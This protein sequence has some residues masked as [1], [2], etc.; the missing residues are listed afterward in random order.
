MAAAG[1]AAASRTM[2]T[3]RVKPPSETCH[4]TCPIAS[5]AG[6][7]AVG[8][9]RAGS[10]EG[11]TDAGA[12]PAASEGVVLVPIETRLRPM[13]SACERPRAERSEAWPPRAEDAPPPRL[14]GSGVSCGV[15]RLE[16]FDFL[17]LA[18]ASASA[19]AAA[20]AASACA[21]A[22]AAALASASAAAAAASRRSWASRRP[23]MPRQRASKRDAARKT[24]MCLR[25]SSWGSTPT[26]RQSRLRP[27][28]QSEGSMPIALIISTHAC[29][30]ACAASSMGSTPSASGGGGAV[31]RDRA[32]A[33]ESTLVHA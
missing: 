14:E 26:L 12:P 24:A 8:S 28:T 18:S 17:P 7:L 33:R 6:S 30:S 9:A 31:G 21:N 27:T 2:R 22:S 10:G 1:A 25:C 15:P 13:P 3:F 16:P 19:A 11:G 32:R 29:R 23:S 5:S 4:T 20:A